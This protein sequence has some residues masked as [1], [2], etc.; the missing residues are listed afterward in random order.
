MI[1]FKQVEFYSSVNALSFHFVWHISNGRCVLDI[2]V[3]T[4]GSTS[5]A[6]PGVEIVSRT[7]HHAGCLT[8]RRCTREMRRIANN[9]TRWWE[10]WSTRWRRCGVTNPGC[11]SPVGIMVS[12]R[13]T[14]QSFLGE[15]ILWQQ[16]T[17]FEPLSRSSLSFNAPKMRRSA[18]RSSTPRVSWCLVAWLQGSFAAECMS[19]LA[20][21]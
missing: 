11:V 12:C 16:T 15:K 7:H 13:P 21:V 1:H 19:H 10:G 6:A 4:R 9:K 2:M 5:R 8:W 3:G 18:C 20:T 17:G 14:L